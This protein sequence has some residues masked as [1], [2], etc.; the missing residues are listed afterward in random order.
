MK[1]LIIIIS[2][3]TIISL[4]ILFSAGIFKKNNNSNST[5]DNKTEQVG[6]KPN[7]PAE[8]R[9]K[10]GIPQNVNYL[11]PAEFS[12]GLLKQDKPYFMNNCN[13]DVLYPIQGLGPDYGW[14]MPKDCRCTEFVQAP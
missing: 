1:E 10:Y 14:K 13:P 2:L 11:L 12:V 7:N 5:P 9:K 3:A 8:I 4:T 6:L